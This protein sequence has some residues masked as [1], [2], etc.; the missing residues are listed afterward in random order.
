MI[1]RGGVTGRPICVGV[2]STSMFGWRA[3]KH[4]RGG[5]D[6]DS[7]VAEPV[8]VPTPSV[9]GGWHA[10]D[11]LKLSTVCACGHTRKEHTGLRMEVCGRCL[12]CDCREFSA[13]P[14]GPPSRE[15]MEVME[16]LR[17]ALVRVERL[18]RLASELS[19]RRNGRT[20]GGSR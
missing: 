4:A 9:R 12:E 15:D 2:A 7:P 14:H 13:A 5:G 3:A 11:P 8:D 17:D 1:R 18:Q 6:P 20:P 19:A 16:K 10:V